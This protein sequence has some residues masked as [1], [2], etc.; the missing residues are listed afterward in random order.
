M[1]DML[2]D[3]RPPA[4]AAGADLP[5]LDSIMAESFWPGEDGINWNIPFNHSLQSNTGT[6]NRAFDFLRDGE[7][8][9]LG[10]IDDGT[11]PEN[12]DAINRM[13]TDVSGSPSSTSEGLSIDLKPKHSTQL[14]GFSNESDP[15]ALHHFPYNHLD[16]VDFFRVTYR[17]QP[18]RGS[19]SR[20]D[21]SSECPPIHFLHSQTGTAVEIRKVVDQCMSSIDDREHLE[22]LVDRDAGVALVR[23]YFKFVFE[24]LPILSR[25][26]ILQD[27][28]TFV[29]EA[30][31]GLLAGIYAL[32]FP[33]TPWDEK[34]CLD[35]A[36][37]KPNIAALWQI[38]YTC[39][40]KEL[41]FPRLS[42][43]QIFLLLLNHAPF[44]TVSVESP[45]AWTLAG[46]MLSM[47]Q[48]L[49]L[50][51]DPTGWSLPPWEIRLRRR[52]WCAVVVEHTWRSITHG[53]SS[54]LHDDDWDV[55][56]LVVD[57]FVVDANV[58]MPDDMRYRSPDY[59]MHLCSLTEIANSV[60]RQFFS[61]RA[62]SRQQSLDT[63]LEQARGPRQRL[64]EWLEGLPAS[65]HINTETNEGDG[66]DSVKS[67]ASLYVAYYTTHI[68]VLRALLRPIINNNVQLDQS[69][70]SVETVL[71]ASRG[72]VQTVI[73][74]IRGLDSRHQSAFW[75][76]YTR[77]CLSYPESSSY[78]EEDFAD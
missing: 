29:A 9:D 51:V 27:V 39:L 65:L 75:P 56:P 78:M 28:Q 61:L 64:L 41:H 26:L 57:D 11:P 59:F 32:A 47:A 19:S 68:L 10:P 46:S 76:A 62:V 44:D 53:R 6:P 8:P 3:T 70:P 66:D 50:N 74:F 22:K 2:G 12:A 72:L 33:F 24:S 31:T 71:Q 37:S 38:S 23:L 49:G 15:F 73:K 5:P 17:I 77:H 21:G 67:H 7:L 63:L 58:S 48:S 34:L 69:H 43:I 30:S 54:M 18:G 60:C 16:E 42:T 36:Y 14:I 20:N 35:S 13:R 1:L 4:I 40:Q 52:L 55:S 25:S 45:F